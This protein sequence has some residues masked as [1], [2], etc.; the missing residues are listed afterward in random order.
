MVVQETF[1][2][3][4]SQVRLL[5]TLMINGFLSQPL[6]QT[7]DLSAID[8]INETTAIDIQ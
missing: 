1:E 3:W 5:M 7:V 8:V 6:P 4:Q 2:H